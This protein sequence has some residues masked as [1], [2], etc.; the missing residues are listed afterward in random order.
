MADANG[1]INIVNSK[2]ESGH[3]CL[4]PRC[5]V[6]RC[7][8]C[9]LVTTVV[10]GEVYSAFIQLMNGSPKPNLPSVENKKVQLTLS[11]AFSASSEAII[12][13]AFVE[14]E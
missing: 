1:S 2:G 10:D 9:P 8:L 3:P 13:F 7:E 12:V 6:K 14:F 11:K 5:N 4:V